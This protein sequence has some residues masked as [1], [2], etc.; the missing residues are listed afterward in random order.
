M[1]NEDTMHSYQPKYLKRRHLATAVAAALLGTGM[2]ASLQAQSWLEEVTVTATKRAENVQ[3]VPLAIS[4][5]SG[6]FTKDNNLDDVKD[7]INITPGITGNSKDSF[8]DAVSVRGIRTQDFGVGGDP[9]AAFFKND[10]YEGRNGAAVTSLYDMERSEV[11]RGPQGFLFGRSSIGG[12]ISV[13]TAKPEIGG[14][15]SG[16]IDVDIGERGH[17][18]VEGAINLPVNDSFAMRVAGYHSEEDGY[19]KNFAGGPDLIAHDKSAI[20]WSTAYQSGKLGVDTTVEYE[21]REQSGSVYRAVNQGDTWQGLL[22][23]GLVNDTMPLGGERDADVDLQGGDADNADILSLG[24]KL[25]YDLGFAEL[26]SNTGYKD[27]DY[28]YSE[29]YDGTSVNLSNYHQD[30]TGDYFQQ[31]FRLTSTG[32]DA[33]SWYAGVSYYKENIDANFLFRTTE[34]A[35]CMYYYASSCSDYYTDF[36]PSDTGYLDEGNNAVG[37]YEGWAGYVDLTYAFN[38]R[39][40][41]SIGARYSKDEKTFSQNVPMPDSY[42]GPWYAYGYTTDGTIKQSDSWSDTT[43]RALVRWRPNDTAMIFASFTQGYKPG[44]F[45]TFSMDF[46]SCA[47]ESVADCYDVDQ[48]VQQGE[49]PLDTFEP[50]TVDSFEIGYKDTLMDGK[51]NVTVTAFA[52]QYQDL[53]VPSN[54]FPSRVLNAGEVAGK[55]VEATVMAALNDNFDLYLGIGYLDTEATHMAPICE[56]DDYDP[57]TMPDT[58]SYCE[59]VQLFWS[60]EWAGSAVLNAHFPVNG[61]QW[62]GNLGVTWESE[63][64]GGY[65]QLA[66][67]KI[68]AYNEWSFRTG[69]RADD[70]WSVIGYV[71]N[72][73][74]QNTYDGMNNNGELVPA[75]FFGMSRPRTIGVSF[76][77]EWE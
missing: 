25:S 47:E 4:A 71:E 22:D 11:L 50:E 60:P 67:T 62:I 69:F 37:E 57:E 44:G 18:V 8:L 14:T 21:T 7:L 64:G 51:A 15:N 19:V 45:G 63:R 32:S 35:I 34:E 13:H 59:G 36:Y 66:E 10:F 40:D 73:T 3:D 61:G 72:L 29:D 53:Q 38:E 39:W 30:Q 70:G 49:F 52:Y 16:Y 2:S 24:V 6:D 20:R 56:L 41:A 77:Y 33:L 43:L 31:E 58:Y 26:V 1:K 27:H 12:A 46:S 74:D 28:Y 9:S 76:G 42:L 23:S 5:F 75:H 65:E 17:G 55:G 68:A 48:G 54:D